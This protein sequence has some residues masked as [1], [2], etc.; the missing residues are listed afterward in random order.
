MIT[1]SLCM[2]VKDEEDTLPRCLASVQGLVEEIIVADTGSSDRTVE[3]AQEGGAR[4][5]S[6][7]W[8]EDFSQ[9]R[10][11]SFSKATQQYCLWLDAD[12]VIDPE[13]REGFLQLKA[14]LPPQTDVVMLPYHT[15]FDSRGTPVL[16]YYRERLIRRLAGLRWQG[17]VHE[18]IPPVGNVVYWDK[19]AVSHRKIHPS[20]PDRNLRIFQS[21]LSQGRD[22]SPR[23]QFYYAR[24]LAAHGRE[25]EAAALWEDFF[26]F[27]EQGWAENKREA[28]RDLSACYLRHGTGGKAAFAALARGHC[29]FGPPRAEL[30]CDLGACFLPAGETIPHSG[31]LVRSRP[32]PRPR[33]DQSGGFVSPGLLR[34]SALHAAV[35]VLLPH[36]QPG[37][38]AESSTG[39][40]GRL[41]SPTIPAFLYNERFFRGQQ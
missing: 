19:A 37:P 34:V 3:L 7:P 21:L 27:G 28:C 12:D 38:L 29:A 24:E 16:T 13:Y 32:D 36:G 25:E 6:F 22:L 14:G 8:T 2:I 31:V 23:E 35:R 1:I 40:A 11:F 33:Q 5:Y 4:V 26:G 10:N 20:D 30:C 17:A 9:A 39:R 41:S 15:A 18:A